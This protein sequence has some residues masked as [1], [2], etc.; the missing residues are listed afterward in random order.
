VIAPATEAQRPCKPMHPKVPGQPSIS[1]VAICN[2]KTNSLGREIKSTFTDSAT[3][4]QLPQS[5]IGWDATLATQVN[6]KH[7]RC[8]I[9]LTDWNHRLKHARWK[10]AL[11][12][13]TRTMKDRLD[14]FVVKLSTEM[15]SSAPLFQAELFLL[16]SHI[17][18]FIFIPRLG[19]VT[20]GKAYLVSL[21][22][23][24]SGIFQ[25]THNETP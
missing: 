12:S 13:A 1:S 14:W 3:V 25:C 2:T 16:S 4:N 23:S 18:C 6:P 24:F 22:V 15:V 17:D 21:S 9:I 7:D 11:C 19:L 10:P 5:G 20:T 8:T